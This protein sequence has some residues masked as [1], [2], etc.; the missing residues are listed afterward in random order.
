MDHWGSQEVL[1][2]YVC[3]E[4][5]RLLHYLGPNIGNDFDRHIVADLSEPRQDG[6]QP[7]CSAFGLRCIGGQVRDQRRHLVRLRLAEIR[8]DDTDQGVHPL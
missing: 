1:D 3:L 4:A 5:K 2:S 8:A 6:L 7:K